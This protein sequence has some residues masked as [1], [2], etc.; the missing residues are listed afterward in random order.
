M[1]N[2]RSQI[3]SL[4][5][6]RFRPHRR[7]P[8]AG[9][10]R[11]EAPVLRL[12]HCADSVEPPPFAPS[13]EESSS[14]LHQIGAL[15]A[16]LAA[17]ESGIE[18]VQHRLARLAEIADPQ[19]L[20]DH[21]WNA[22]QAARQTAIDREIRAIDERA[23]STEADGAKLLDGTWSV[24]LADASMG[25][26]RTLRIASVA[27]HCLGRERIGGFLSSLAS[28]DSQPI[29]R[30]DPARNRAVIRCAMLQVAAAREQVAAFRRDA[31]DPLRR[32]FEVIS[33]NVEAAEDAFEE[34]DLAR[35]ASRL[36]RID[37]LLNACPRA[38]HPGLGQSFSLPDSTRAEPGEAGV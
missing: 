18:E 1:S 33:A 16:V 23:A 11:A 3:G 14:V 21:Q 26:V 13:G 22:L 10:P 38:P 5:A 15:S 31:L 2:G 20:S 17:A 27:S 25:G 29:N 35:Q 4:L 30:S 19:G 7:P 9:R 32:T 24:A 36:T 8:S 28:A 34:V 6:A 37:A 12:T